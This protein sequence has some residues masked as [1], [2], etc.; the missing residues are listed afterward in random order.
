MTLRWLRPTLTRRLIGA[1]LLALTLFAV[2]ILVEDQLDIQQT[3]ATDPGVRQFGRQL[4]AGL[5]PIDDAVLAAHVL[6]AHLRHVNQLRERQ[7]M[8]PGPLL[9]QLVDLSGNS[10]YAT[11]PAA[12]IARPG[13]GQH[14]IAGKSYW[15]YRQDGRRW[16]LR[17]AEPAVSRAGLLSFASWELG[18]Q[19]LLG[20]PLM[21]LPLWLAVYTGLAPLR[22]LARRLHGVDLKQDVAPMNLDLRYGELQPLGEAFDALLRRLRQHRARER[23]F[24]HEAAHELRTPLA[25]VAMQAHALVQARDAASR[26]TA[27]AA[28]QQAV[29][30]SA[31]LSRQ[32]LDLASLDNDQPAAPGALDLAHYCAD[33][34]A[35]QAG[36]ARGRGIELTLDAPDQMPV[37]V[38][39]LALHS[40]LQNLLDNALRYVDAG[41]RV[42]VRLRLAP[43]GPRIDVADNG[44]GIALADRPLVFE[45]FWRGAG[46]CV[47]GTGLGLAIVARATER[48]GGQISVGDGLVRPDGG[49]GV[50]FELQLPAC[51]LG[52]P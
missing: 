43:D 17:L 22:R 1:L 28:L 31:H 49:C 37:H 52:V 45:R 9:A 3:L 24:V 4:A 39:T 29:A 18:K 35:E 47:S 42:E 6:Q 21:L 2:L 27:A 34:L 50:R 20:F 30:R 48:L 46:A 23:A 44:P 10:I 19:L 33:R 41:G 40:V 26:D 16:S 25:V 51:V 15:T 5:E 38:D 14:D 11:S 8:F 12:E 13:V 7:P 32:L 36:I